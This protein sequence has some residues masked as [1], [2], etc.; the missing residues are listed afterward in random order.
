MYFD[1]L[2][3]TVILA[4]ANCGLLCWVAFK[5]LKLEKFQTG[6]AQSNLELINQS[7]NR[8]SQ[9]TEVLERINQPVRMTETSTAQNNE[10]ECETGKER[11]AIYLLRK[12]E[13][14]RVISRKLGLSRSEM[15]LLVAS[16]KLGNSQR[17]NLTAV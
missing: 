7:L 15:D 14:P 16:E 17:T 12:G 13:N 11:R 6:E 2:S 10:E 4:I 5:I 9:I 1:A 8:L 3:L